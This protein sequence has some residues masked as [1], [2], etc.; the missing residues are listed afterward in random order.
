M[1]IPV[2]PLANARY[3]GWHTD[4]IESTVT[5]QRIDA[6][7]RCD[8]VILRPDIYYKAWGVNVIKQLKDTPK[9]AYV[10]APVHTKTYNVFVTSPY[11]FA[12]KDLCAKN[13]AWVYS[14]SGAIQKQ[15]KGYDTYVSPALVDVNEHAK[16]TKGLIW[17]AGVWVAIL[18][19]GLVTNQIYCY[20]PSQQDLNRNGRPDVVELGWNR[21]AERQRVGL[22]RWVKWLY[23]FNVPVIANGGWEPTGVGL[24]DRKYTRFPPEM[25]VSWLMQYCAGMMCEKFAEYPYY[26]YTKYRMDAGPA[27]SLLWD[28]YA[29][30]VRAW[31]KAGRV[32]LMG[33]SDWDRGDLGRKFVGASAGVLGAT[34]L[35]TVPDYGLPVGDVVDALSGK[36]PEDVADNWSLYHW[37]REYERA[38]VTVYPEK[39]ETTVKWR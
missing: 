28:L 14:A 34:S 21:V 12:I 2:L 35:H 5:R 9:I 17:D 29:R 11:E 26:W 7:K 25:K 27:R 31:R 4:L 22:E 16:I 23:Y 20:D 24:K 37:E 15:P 6:M 8:A 33:G 36:S 3:V 32:V 39:R 19:D 1:P 13:Q 10:R 18:A 38:V 30:C